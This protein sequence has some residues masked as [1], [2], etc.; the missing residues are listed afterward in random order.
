MTKG[1]RLTL[2]LERL[3]PEVVNNLDQLCEKHKGPHYLR[4]VLLDRQNRIKLPL[5][6]RG[7][8][9]KADNDFVQELSRLGVDYKIER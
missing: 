9:V 2:P 6:A 1:I 4:M 3:T 8:K 5:A 7:R